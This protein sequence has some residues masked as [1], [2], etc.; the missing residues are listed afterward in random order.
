MRFI[1]HNYAEFQFE[2]TAML[3]DEFRVRFWTQVV[4][5]MNCAS[6]SFG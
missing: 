3:M 6:V 4:P 1:D 2:Q 5:G